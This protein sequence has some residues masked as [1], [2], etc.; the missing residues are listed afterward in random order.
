M[1]VCWC[2][3]PVFYWRILL[4]ILLLH[5]LINKLHTRTA[6]L[7]KLIDGCSTRWPR[8]PFPASCHNSTPC[9]LC[10]ACCC[11]LNKYDHE[12]VKSKKQK[13]VVHVLVGSSR[14]TI[15][16]IDIKAT[17]EEA[18]M[19]I[20]QVT[21]IKFFVLGKKKP[22]HTLQTISSCEKTQFFF[23]FL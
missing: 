5:F 15:P 13:N 12:I 6:R 23:I 19:A 8:G 4:S 18:K 3:F 21:V 22:A 11:V 17:K 7:T 10:V 20:G 2:G 16:Q 1:R 9:F 14:D